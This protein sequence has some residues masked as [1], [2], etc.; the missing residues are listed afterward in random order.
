M[1]ADIRSWRG[2]LLA[3]A[4]GLF[5]FLALLEGGLRIWS[6]TAAWTAQWRTLSRAAE[7]GPYRILCLGE[8]TTAKQYPPF[9]EAAL[10]ARDPG[11]RYV[12]IDG[13]VAGVNTDFL[14]R[15]LEEDLDRWRPHA[16]AAMMGTNDRGVA[17]YREAPGSRSWL[18]RSS[19]AVRLLSLL[20]MN[21]ASRRNALVKT[22][23]GSR[24]P[25]PLSRDKLARVRGWN[26][27]SPFPITISAGGGAGNWPWR[28]TTRA[29]PRPG[30]P[31]T[32]G[33]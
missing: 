7:P 18:F 24:G 29:G 11:R 28:R 31:A 3:L 10:N 25:G 33:S 17:L 14:L 16:V 5:A 6:R 9:L 1:S 19:R 8:S 27:S 22:G 23:S 30:R 4:A 20:W 12:A 26:P 15:R 13:G 32:R 2:R 21:A